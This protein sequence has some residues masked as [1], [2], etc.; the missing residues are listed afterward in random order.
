MFLQQTLNEC[1]E[2]AVLHECTRKFFPVPVLFD[3]F[4][5]FMK[6]KKPYSKVRLNSKFEMFYFPS[7]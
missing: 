2:S 6:N 7:I 4:F 3:F 1:L 5:S